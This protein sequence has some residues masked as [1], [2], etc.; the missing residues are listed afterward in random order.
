MP[1][2]MELLLKKKVVVYPV[3][4]VTLHPKALILVSLS[5]STETAPTR[6]SAPPPRQISLIPL[7]SEDATTNLQALQGRHDYCLLAC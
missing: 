4:A 2:R 3:N 7:I 5:G 6:L 1:N